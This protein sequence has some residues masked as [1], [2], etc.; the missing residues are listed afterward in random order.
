LE[1]WVFTFSSKSA[2]Q[3]N[4]TRTWKVY[5]KIAITNDCRKVKYLSLNE[6]AL[7]QH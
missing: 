3:S 7:S 1:N 6:R 5:P 4:S 2:I